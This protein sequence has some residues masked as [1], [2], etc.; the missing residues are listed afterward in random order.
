M[1]VGLMKSVLAHLHQSRLLADNGPTF[2]AKYLTSDTIGSKKIYIDFKWEGDELVTT[3]QVTYKLVQDPLEIEINIKL[4][5][6]M[7]W[8]RWNGQEYTVGANLNMELFDDKIVPD[9]C[10]VS[11]IKGENGCP[12]FWITQAGFFQL[13]L[14]PFEF[15][16]C[17]QTPGSV[18]GEQFLFVVRLLQRVQ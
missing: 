8:L 12:V 18:V 6:L 14:L 13:Q 2:K 10:V 7:R 15:L 1:G 9:L 17:E 5:K 4:A 3:N 11:D 16:E